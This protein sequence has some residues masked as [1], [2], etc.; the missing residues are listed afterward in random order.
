MTEAPGGGEQAFDSGYANRTL[1][2]LSVV[3]GLIIYVDIMLTP[4]LPKIVAEYGVTIDQASLLISLYTV[5]GVAVIPIFGKLGDIYGKKRV[6]MYILVTYVVAAT[7]TS[8]APSFDL[9][10][11]SRFVQGVG[12]GVFALCF[13]LAREQ[14]PRKLVPRAQGVISAVQLSGGALGLLGGALVTSD[15]GW[16]GN[17]HIA[18]PVIAVLTALIYFVV[19]E[20]PNKKP[21]VSLDYVGAAWL[22]ASLIAIVL[23]LSEGTSW[24]WTSTSI[25]GLL[26]AGT[27]ALVPL[28]L[29]ERRVAEPVLDL[30]L[31]RQR[32]VMVANL[33]VVSFGLS[34]GIAFQA[35]VY[36]LE[37]P[38]PSGF[39][40]SIIEV[41][42][43]LLPLVVVTLPVAL[44]VATL[45]PKYG[46]KPF[47]YAGSL[48]AAAGF[49]LLSTYTGPLQM[50]AY[51]MVYAFGGGMLTV[52]IQN[53]L[54]LSIAKGEM[55]LG[56]S[57][58]TTF[59]YVGQTLGAPIAGALLSTFVASYSVSGQVISLPTRAAFQYCF[60]APVVA[61]IAVGLLSIFAREVI[62]KNQD[63]GHGS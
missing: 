35:L 23:G 7:A 60:Y 1:V 16:Q 27:V 14:F 20:S 6:M 28:G 10:L 52:S 45:I 34:S 39:G 57:L 2:L 18:V 32:N 30:K 63:K 31:L 53:L 3:A 51:L 48:L 22:G 56:T 37:L 58:N 50:A 55:S 13:S 47:L 40:I 46:V 11:V 49:F 17:Y 8:F 21:G 36:A 38:P 5:L 26:I 42:L 41:G 19:R 62:G 54:V 12:L 29:Y 15:F 24:G 59:R 4:A 25:L 44:G 9:I 61:F 43:Y 33:L